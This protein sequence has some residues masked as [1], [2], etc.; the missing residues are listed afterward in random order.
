MK[1]VESLAELF[2]TRSE[3]GGSV[4]FVPTMGAL[5][6]G[7]QSLMRAA[8]AQCE[9][10]IVSIFVNPT[11]FGPSEDFEQYPR[12]READ[13]KACQQAGVEVVWFPAVEEMYPQNSQTVV[14]VKPL[15][16]DFEGSARPGHFAG[17]ATIVSKL[18]HAVSPHKAYFGQKDLQQLVLIQRMTADLLF[19]IEVVGVPTSREANGLARSSRNSYL[20]SAIRERAGEIYH[21]LQEVQRAH[22]RGERDPDA[23]EQI[24]RFCLEQLPGA[25]LE[26]FDLIDPLFSRAYK[27]GEL[28]ERGFCTVAVR[29]AGVRLIDNI[30]LCS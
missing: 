10:V 27:E 19:P 25:E 29:L 6:E 18:F 9:H 5:H 26:R 8:S 23:L 2:A 16:R 13:L 15:G 24:F 14:E 4:G 11:Q 20:D 12:S 28:I 3:M 7:H 21:G 30:D 1:A 22:S 17:V